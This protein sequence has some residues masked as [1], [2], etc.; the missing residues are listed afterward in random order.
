MVVLAFYGAKG[1]A[2][3]D[4]TPQ[5]QENQH[6]RYHRDNGSGG[7]VVPGNACGSKIVERT[8]G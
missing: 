2:P 5:N 7:D 8:N 6:G 3:H 1:K 4:I